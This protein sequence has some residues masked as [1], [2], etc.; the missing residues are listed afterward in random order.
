MFAKPINLIAVYII[1]S[2]NLAIVMI[3][4]LILII[5]FV[6]FRGNVLVIDGFLFQRIEFLFFAIVFLVSFLMLFYMVLDFIFGFS[7]LNS[8]KGCK[9]YDSL[10]D[11]DF[12]TDIFKETQN[13]FGQW[14]VKLYIKESPEI[15]AYAVGSVRRK[16]MILTS[17]LINHYYNSISD[18]KD[19]LIAVRS[20][21]AHEMSHLI[22]NDFLPTFLFIANQR[23]TNFVSY[24]IRFIFN[25]VAGISAMI[26]IAGFVL[27]NM[28]ILLYNI[29]NFFLNLFNRLIVTNIYNFLHKFISKN[30][31]YRADRQ[32]AKAFGG[33]NMAFALQFL[34]KDGYFNLFSDH[35]KT[36]NRIKKVK[37]VE[38]TSFA[39]SQTLIDGFSNYFALMFL[40]VVCCYFAKEAKIDVMIRIYLENHQEINDKIMY[41]WQMIESVINYFFK[42]YY[43]T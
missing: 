43:A 1:T 13:K 16:A 27:N 30:I 18:R 28:L 20:I 2:I 3:P 34:G 35:P 31:E 7:V 25:F 23:V 8:L 21:M 6:N 14:Q 12:L 10:K 41:F 29:I 5:P 39:V 22:N 37:D 38:A 36:V 32:A 17:G 11:Y 40:L 42:R 26:P 9:R 19:F 33:Q 15:N 24:L 4:T